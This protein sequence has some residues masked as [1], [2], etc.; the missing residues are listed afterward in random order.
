MRLGLTDS[1]Y[2]YLFSGPAGFGDRGSAYFDSKGFP[3]P[4]FLSTPVAIPRPQALEWLINR[5]AELGLPVVHGGP[6]VFDDPAY[7]AKIKSL[8]KEKGLEMI[9]AL[10]VDLIAGGEATRASIENAE[11]FLDG[12]RRFGDVRISKFCVSPMTRNRFRNDPPLR[13]QLDRIIANIKP[14][15]RA[16]EEAGIVLAFENHLDYRASEVVEIIEAVDSSNL[17]FLF[18]MGNTTVVIEDPVEA[19]KVAAPY[20]VLCH[21]KDVRIL[22]W[23]PSALF[24][25]AIFAT[26]LGRGNV[27]VVKICEILQEKAP[28][29]RNLCL[30]L[31]NMPVPPNEDEDL[32]VVEGIKWAKENLARFLG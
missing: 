24:V 9:P 27:D 21:L 12:F 28:D 1:S 14:V 16:A 29:P 22:P 4:Y 26:P 30:S 11:K 10:G 3:A 31:E 5:T 32:W 8:V 20:T 17:Q 23:T 6:R 7:I 2:Q 19:A 18:D 13:E 15:V 25:A